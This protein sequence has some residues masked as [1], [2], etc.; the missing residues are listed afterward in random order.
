[1]PIAS[2]LQYSSCPNLQSHSCSHTGLET[3]LRKLVSTLAMQEK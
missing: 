1:M 3:S 2:K